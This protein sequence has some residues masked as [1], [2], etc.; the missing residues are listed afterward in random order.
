MYINIIFFKRNYFYIIYMIIS[1]FTHFLCQKSI[2]IH[3]IV[4]HVSLTPGVS[5]LYVDSWN[6]QILLKLMLY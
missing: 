6:L 3:M 2:F 4:K 1:N 5:I